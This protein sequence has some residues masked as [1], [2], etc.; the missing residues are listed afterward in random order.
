MQRIAQA[1]DVRVRRH[2]AQ[3]RAPITVLD[4]RAVDQDTRSFGPSFSTSPLIGVAPRS[5]ERPRITAVLMSINGRVTPLRPFSARPPL[6]EREFG[7]EQQPRAQHIGERVRLIGEVGG[8]Y[9][10]ETAVF[11]QCGGPFGHRS[12]S[13]LAARTIRAVTFWNAEYSVPRAVRTGAV[14]A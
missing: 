10:P 4:H 11:V 8:Q 5:P 14:A 12:A 13:G 6:R 9:Q 3:P 1:Q 2:D 7:Q